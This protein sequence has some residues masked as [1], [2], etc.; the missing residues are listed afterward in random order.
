MSDAQTYG[1]RWHSL[2]RQS[3]GVDAFLMR[4]SEGS[5]GLRTVVNICETVIVAR[6]HEMD[7]Q[8]RASRE[9]GNPSR[10]MNVASMASTYAA[11]IRFSS[12]IAAR[13]V[14]LSMLRSYNWPVSGSGTHLHDPDQEKPTRKKYK[15]RRYA[16]TLRHGW[17]L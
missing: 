16:S 11:N 12:G 2:I 13:I 7:V 6:Q 8:I 3:L 17:R 10:L 5:P 1:S 4:V 14:Q 15:E 9:S